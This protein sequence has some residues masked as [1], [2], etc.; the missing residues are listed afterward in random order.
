MP[1]L[2]QIL[3]RAGEVTIQE[4]LGSETIGLLGKMDR[5]YTRP[6]A[7]KDLILDSLGWEGIL[8]DS[9]IRLK[10]LE[11]LREE[12]ALDLLKWM[13]VKPTKTAFLELRSLSIPKGSNREEKLFSYFGLDAPSREWENSKPS[14]EIIDPEYQVFPHQVEM[15]HQLSDMIH[16]E[17]KRV[18]VH[19]PTGSGKTR[20]TMNFIAEYFRKNPGITILWLA[21]SEELCEQAIHEFSRSWKSLGNQPTRIIRH[22]G[23]HSV[24]QSI[25]GNTF[26]VSGLGKMVQALKTSVDLFN[27]LM[28]ELKLIV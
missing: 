6:Q 19:M 8:L 11:L 26:L 1:S 14:E 5:E 21:Y 18:I 15:I 12:E 3:S 13:G 7:L 22:F 16:D 27:L 10:V 24:P 2:T 9:Q 4:L 23:A 28:P 25:E 20:T 17:S